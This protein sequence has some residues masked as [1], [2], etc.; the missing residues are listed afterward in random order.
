[1]RVPSIRDTSQRSIPIAQLSKVLA[2]A[3]IDAMVVDANSDQRTAT[4]NGGCAAFGAACRNAPSHACAAATP[5]SFSAFSSSG[6]SVLMT[7]PLS[8]GICTDREYLAAL[9]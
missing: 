4:G 2:D 3:T 8:Q 1:V 6:S 5:I 9:S 7:R